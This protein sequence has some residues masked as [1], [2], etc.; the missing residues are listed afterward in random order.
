MTAAPAS[1][2]LIPAPVD[3]GPEPVSI[4]REPHALTAARTARSAA[5][6]W[7]GKERGSD[8]TRNELSNGQWRFHA[9]YAIPADAPNQFGRYASL[10]HRDALAASQM[11]ERQYA[12]AIR[13]DMG[14]VCGPEYLDISIVRLKQT[15][16]ELQALA[17]ARSGTLNA[18]SQSLDAA[19][20]EVIKAGEPLSRAELRRTNWVVWLDGP[21]PPN[22]CGEAMLYDDHT[23]S[24]SNLNNLAGKVAV[25]Y[26]YDGAF[27]GPNTVRHEIT[28]TLGAV[29]SAATSYDGTGHCRDAIEDTMCAPGA[30]Q[31][32]DG[33]YYG[34][35]FDYG[36]DDY[37]DPAGGTL[38]WWTVNLSRFLCPDV[39]CNGPP[40]DLN[41]QGATTARPQPGG[42]GRAGERR[43][44]KLSVRRS[45][46]SGRWRVSVL[47]RG[48]GRALL[49]VRC[50]TA[51][52]GKVRVIY[53]KRI[54]LPR[55]VKPTRTCMSKPRVYVKRL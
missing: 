40:A 36:N 18:V 22:T 15:T 2:S 12:R 28:H 32:A 8:E 42:V 50:R 27:C 26:Q 47:A 37:W 30:P 48:S 31:R 23:R 44:V 13:Y 21:A 14:T 20:F 6:D 7:C 3:T 38:S 29:V 51:R 52:G 5:A 46:R 53:R 24:E 19:G 33:S 35:F 17:T 16:A 41:Q 49:Q 54:R 39:T 10:I 11:I 43:P 55:R 1:A 25:I 34:L 9:I 4:D 45:R